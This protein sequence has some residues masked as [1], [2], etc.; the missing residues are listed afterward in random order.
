MRQLIKVV[1][2]NRHLH[3][4]YSLIKR[5]SLGLGAVKTVS[6]VQEEPFTEHQKC[7]ESWRQSKKGHYLMSSG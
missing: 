7:E 5:V 2:K 3:K 4:G 6:M 1:K